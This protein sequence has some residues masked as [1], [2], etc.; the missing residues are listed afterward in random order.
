M[1]K[2]FISGSRSIHFLPAAALDAIDRIIAQNMS[3]L[4]GD[5]KGVDTAIQRYLKTKHYAN[6]AVCH[7]GATPRNNLGFNT[8][9]VNGNYQTDKDQFMGK[10]ATYGL[11]I[12]DGLSEGTRKNI[13][14]AKTKV[15]KS[16]SD[17][18]RCTI[19]E[20]PSANGGVQLP[21]TFHAQSN[22][23]IPLCLDCYKS[24]KLKTECDRRGILC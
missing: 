18:S 3:I 17:N 22:P 7:I 21:I 10:T 19:C 8:I 12:W 6:V 16:N 2:V 24:G 23:R 14:R 9:Q 11:A 4:V 13:E 15:V 5:C 1:T 20:G